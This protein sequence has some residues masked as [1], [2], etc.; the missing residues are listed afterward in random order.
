[1]SWFILALAMPVIVAWYNGST[2]FFGLSVSVVGLILYFL[3]IALIRAYI[4]KRAPDTLRDDSWEKTARTGVVPKWVS[5][6]GMVGMGFVPSGIVVIILL[7][8]GVIIN[9][10]SGISGLMKSN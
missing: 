3:N 10:S 9:M 7:K 8:V 1:M 4:A 5:V 2:Y 6:I